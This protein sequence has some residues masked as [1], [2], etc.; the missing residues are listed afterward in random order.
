LL[1]HLIITTTALPFQ[2]AKWKF[3]RVTS[4][5][6]DYF[7][8]I[9]PK[10]ILF[11]IHLHKWNKRSV[12]DFEHRYTLQMILHKLKKFACFDSRV[13]LGLYNL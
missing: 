3:V 2:L 4:S 8:T 11:T 12:T 5:R 6:N 7:V 13:P 10:Y 9:S 1:N